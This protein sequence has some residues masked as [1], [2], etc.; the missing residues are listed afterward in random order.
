MANQLPVFNHLFH[1]VGRTLDNFSRS[2]PVDNS[3]VESPDN[4]RHD[5]SGY[6]RL[7]QQVR[8]VKTQTYGRKRCLFKLTF[9]ITTYYKQSVN[10]DRDGKKMK[11]SHSASKY[12]STTKATVSVTCSTSPVTTVYTLF[13]GLNCFIYSKCIVLCNAGL[14]IK[15]FCFGYPILTMECFIILRIHNL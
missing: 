6:G 8:A 2:N 14:L 12:R 7:K 1:G 13:R 10:G 9:S 3:L 11:T 15:L 4:S 5:D